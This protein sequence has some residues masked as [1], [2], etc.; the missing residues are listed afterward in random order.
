MRVPIEIDERNH[1]LKCENIVI[2]FAFSMQSLNAINFAQ[3][4]TL[5]ASVGL[6]P[7]FLDARS[8]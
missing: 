2:A 3:F 1:E 7:P 6:L 4:A 8:T 5:N